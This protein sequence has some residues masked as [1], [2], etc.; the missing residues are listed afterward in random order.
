MDITYFGVMI[1]VLAVVLAAIG[2]AIPVMQWVF[3]SRRVQ[4]FDELNRAKQDYCQALSLI[5]DLQTA[6]WYV[7]EISTAWHVDALEAEE[8]YSRSPSAI[9]SGSVFQINLEVCELRRNLVAVLHGRE[10]EIA[11]ALLSLV[12]YGVLD[13]PNVRARVIEYLTL[14]D[15]KGRFQASEEI[16]RAWDLTKLRL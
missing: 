6:L 9:T 5:D 15:A 12:E 3:D 7:E 16:R 10:R 11:D 13:R 14:L 4:L 2:V 1:A 8:A